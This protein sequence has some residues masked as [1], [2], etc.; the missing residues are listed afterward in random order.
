MHYKDVYCN[1]CE[2]TCEKISKKNRRK[3]APSDVQI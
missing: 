1:F 3:K 2:I